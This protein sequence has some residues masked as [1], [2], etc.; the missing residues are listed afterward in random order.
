MADREA[1]TPTVR[2]RARDWRRIAFLIC[3]DWTHADDILQMSLLRLYRHWHR[4][5]PEGLDAYARKVIVR[6]AIDES[7]RAHRRAEVLSEPPD[8]P[9][10]GVPVDDHVDVRE[11]LSKVPPRQRA[12][13]A[14]RFYCDLTV[15]QT[16]SALRIS[17]GTVKSQTTRGLTTLRS[18]LPESA[19]FAQLG[20]QGD[21]R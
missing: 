10:G 2:R 7:R 11:A 20:T 19:R 15:A 1:F 3:G 18:F 16:A 17:E 5:D 8:A 21:G 9:A 6:V 12:V 14:L 4:I 13:L